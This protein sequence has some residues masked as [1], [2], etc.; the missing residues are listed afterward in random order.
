MSLAIDV[1]KVKFVLLQDGWHS[2]KQ[3]NG[4]STFEI[5]CYEYLRRDPEDEY[6]NPYIYP[7]GP[8]KTGAQWNEPDGQTI[9]VPITSIIAVK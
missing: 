4:I 7:Q 6:A 1:D 3:H 8:I 2:V 9:Y 5:D